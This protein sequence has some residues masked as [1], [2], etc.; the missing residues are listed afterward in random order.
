M[1]L[2]GVCDRFNN[3]IAK[4]VFMT[5]AIQAIHQAGS[6]YI[7]LNDEEQLGLQQMLFHIE[8]ELKEIRDCVGENVGY[9]E[10]AN[11]AGKSLETAG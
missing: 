6:C 3:V 1:E 7:P 9:L 11:R 2:K 8:E 4:N 5:T 10:L